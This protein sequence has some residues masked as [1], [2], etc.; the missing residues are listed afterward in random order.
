LF[1]LGCI[2][3]LATPLHATAA[4]H[5]PGKFNVSQLGAATYT[6]PIAV[7]PGTAGMAPALSLSFNSQSSS[8]LM[9]K[10]WSLGGLSSI[11]RC[12]QT[13]GQDGTVLG[14]VQFDAND[15][16]CLD[17][18]RLVVSNGLAYGTEGAEYRTENDNFSQIISYGNV[19]GGPVSFK[20]WTKAGRVMEYG[21]TSDSRIEAQG[22]G[23]VRIWAI[24]R[25]QDIK[26]N[27]L[28]IA[29][30]E[31][32]ANGDFYP[33][34]IDYTGNVNT[35]MTTNNSVRLTYE[36]LPIFV[37]AYKMGSLVQSTVRLKNIDAYTNEER[38]HNYQLSYVNDVLTKRSRLNGI[39]Q[40]QGD[41]TTCL[42]TIKFDWQELGA[43][44]HT[45]G[46][47][48]TSGIV[49]ESNTGLGPRSVLALD[50]NQDGKTDLLQHI[51]KDGNSWL[52]PMYSNGAGFTVGEAIKLEGMYSNFLTGD[53]DGDG[54]TDL[55]SVGTSPEGVRQIHILFST[56]TGFRLVDGGRHYSEKI[57]NEIYL[58]SYGHPIIMDVDG[59]G[60]ADIVEFWNDGFFTYEMWI[61]IS[62]FDGTSFGAPVWK[63]IHTR[64]GKYSTQVNMIPMDINGDGKMDLVEIWTA[65]DTQDNTFI[66][67]ILSNG[68][69]FIPGA[70]IDSG[71][72][73]NQYNGSGVIQ[74]ILPLDLNGDG[75]MDMVFGGMQYDPNVFLRQNYHLHTFYSNGITLTPGKSEIFLGEQST[76]YNMGINPDTLTASDINGD[77][78]TDLL[79]TW[80]GH[81][82][83]FDD[84]KLFIQ[85]IISQGQGF[86]LNQP[87]YDTGQ[88]WATVWHVVQDPDGNYI[89]QIVSPEFI[90]LDINGDGKMDLVQQKYKQPVFNRPSEPSYFLPYVVDKGIGDLMTGITN[91]LGAKTTIN[92]AP[93]SDSATYV[94]DTAFTYPLTNV[95]MPLYVVA[96]TDLPGGKEGSESFKYRYGGL[97]KDRSRNELTGFRWKEEQQLSTGLTTKI[98]YRQDWPYAGMMINSSISLAG[99]GHA[100]LLSQSASQLACIDTF[101]GAPCVLRPGR[102]YFPFASESTNQKW[103]LNGAALP[104]QKNTIAYDIWGNATDSTSSVSAEGETWTTHVVNTYY[105][106][107][108]GKWLIGQ[109]KSTGVTNTV[110]AY[111]GP[112]LSPGGSGTPGDGNGSGNPGG[113]TP[114]TGTLPSTVSWLAAFTPPA[115]TNPGRVVPLQVQVNGAAP[116]AGTVT[117]FDGDAALAVIALDGTG[118]ASFSVALNGIGGHTLRA[119]YSGDARNA[120]SAV[121]AVV[122]VNVDLTPIL[123]LLLDD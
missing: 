94:R 57:P 80:Y 77:G 54:K 51:H 43:V 75:M 58:G 42:P 104:E 109:L 68:T 31:D 52:I 86:L 11:T 36:T 74:H 102:S 28:T 71:F 6:V 99:K 41:R 119:V 30:T 87:R 8:G 48:V 5:T 66:L 13:P 91:G 70:W 112:T 118:K 95:Q 1:F 79:L 123:M 82:P 32:N 65:N 122:T 84:A 69:D 4:I 63:K 85:P 67:P 64:K 14:A 98:E 47:W 45:P 81:A 55:I 38:T 7:P 21:N 76:T 93:L 115:Q 120:S 106:A 20:V 100:D 83:T 90:V 50:L 25:E 59:D 22:K 33:I 15:R 107:D 40:C 12:A 62:K 114:G 92:Y 73:Q 34:R 35:G 108:T 53:V 121:S 117:F 24:N 111:S 72:Y 110:P 29:Y 9:G 105:P 96:S 37:P 78:K 46:E 18:Q 27:Y 103:D 61:S 19:A 89:Q 44:T 113:S 26:G 101:S 116:L 56:G 10:G 2:I 97:K 3:A 16:F 88:K 17:G 23:W 39:T 60:K 49:M